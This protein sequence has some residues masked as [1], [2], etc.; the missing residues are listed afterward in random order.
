MSVS[1]SLETDIYSAFNTPEKRYEPLVQL[2]Y[3]SDQL[4]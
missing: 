3:K 4:S 2:K 1:S